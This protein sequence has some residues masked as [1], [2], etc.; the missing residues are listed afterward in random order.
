MQL[1]DNSRI[2][3]SAGEEEAVDALIAANASAS[4][5]FSR[6]DPGETGPV[7]VQINN[8]VYE[9]GERGEVKVISLG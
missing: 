9:V 8:A 1:V 7:V 4:I 3:M 5:S 6:R 2:P